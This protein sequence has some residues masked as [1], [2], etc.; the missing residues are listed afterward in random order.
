VSAALA[1]MAATLF[2][3][4]TLAVIA[5]AVMCSWD[6]NRDAHRW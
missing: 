2:V 4:V 1:E 3:A 6:A 5:I